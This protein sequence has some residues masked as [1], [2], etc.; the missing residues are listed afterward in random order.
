VKQSSTLP[1][2]KAPRRSFQAFT[3]IEL[4]VVIAIIAI[5]AAILFPVFQK[6]RENARRASCQSNMKQLGIAVTQYVQDSDEIYPIGCNNGWNQTWA[7]AA[8]PYIKSL[9][10]FRCPDDSSTTYP[11]SAPNWLN[12]GWAGVPISYAA[13]GYMAYEN[14]DSNW[15]VI[16]VMGMVQP[17]SIPGGWMGNTTRSLAS[18]GRPAD[19]IMIAEKHEDDVA[20]NPKSNYG[21]LTVWGP[22]AIFT[23]VN[24]WD[25]WASGEIPD[26][27]LPAAAY[28][29]GPDG[30]V[31]TKHNNMSNFLFV[32]GHVKTMRPYLTNPDNKNHP[33]LNMWDATRQ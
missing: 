20:K 23:N 29:N 33:E 13:N 18:A 5:L 7:D 28:P 25:Q 31:S 19:T 8:Q 26:G 11:A 2:V 30:A 10:V 24:W 27:T 22:G 16:G 3:L 17:K 12:A 32:D 15:D 9:A 21:N 14:S 1:G 4:L 6:V